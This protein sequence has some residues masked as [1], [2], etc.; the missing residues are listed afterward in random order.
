[1]A[2]LTNAG[3]SDAEEGAPPHAVVGPGAPQPPIGR[4]RRI[5]VQVIIWGTT[6]LAV[7]AIF[8]VWANRQLLNPDNWGNTSA[9]LLQH[10]E[11]RTAVSNYLVGQVR[12]RRAIAPSLRHYPALT[13]GVVAA[14]L[15]LIFMWG[16]IPATHRPAGIIVFTVL[17]MLGTG[18]L[19]AQTANEF[20]DRSPR[21]PQIE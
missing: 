8:A 15:L 9:K 1:V 11:V 6:V 14:L 10:A 3:A 21:G 17:A 13:F 19:R 18:V 20:P 12:M 7:L 4:G 2:E 5:T 16:P